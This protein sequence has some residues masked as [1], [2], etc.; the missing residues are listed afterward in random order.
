MI[1]EWLKSN[2][3]LTGA[4]IGLIIPVPAAFVFALLTRFIQIAFHVLT[5]VRM[6][7]MFLLGLAVN[8]IIMRHYIKKLKLENTGK[9]ILVVTF[10]LIAVFFIFLANSTFMLPF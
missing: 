1:K 2:N 3:F 8:L 6:A 4:I 5:E 9:G 7:D 10:G